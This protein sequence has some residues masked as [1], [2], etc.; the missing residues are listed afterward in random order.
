MLCNPYGYW[1]AGHVN[2]VIPAYGFA[3][4]LALSKSECPCGA[5]AGIHFKTKQIHWIP[6]FVAL[7]LPSECL[8]RSMKGLLNK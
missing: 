5:K 2:S 4:A 1:S 6:W 7:P 3:S 8:S